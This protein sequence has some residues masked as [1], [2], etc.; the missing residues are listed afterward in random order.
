MIEGDEGASVLLVGWG[1]TY[2]SLKATLMQCH[3]E[4]VPVALL[5]LRHLNPLP[6]GL[7]KVLKHYQTVLVAELNSGQLCQL[8]RA[9]YLVDAESLGQCNGQPYT[10]SRLVKAI[11]GFVQM[12]TAEVSHE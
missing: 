2:G 8:L 5:H 11:K 12:T 3:A 10:T 7:G 6:E 1:S 9:T 4:G